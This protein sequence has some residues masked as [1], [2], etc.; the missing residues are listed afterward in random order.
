MARKKKELTEGE[1]V[2]K[3]IEADYEASLKA[4]KGGK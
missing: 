4:I 2:E 1:A 3:A